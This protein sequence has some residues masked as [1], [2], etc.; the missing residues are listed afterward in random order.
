MEKIPETV[1]EMVQDFLCTLA[2][3]ELARRLIRF[4]KGGTVDPVQDNPGRPQDKA[5][6]PL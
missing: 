4:G 6:L 5:T 1:E 2:L 3:L